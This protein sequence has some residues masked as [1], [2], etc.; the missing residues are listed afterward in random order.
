MKWW[1]CIKHQVTL[2]RCPQR[3]TL[4][5]RQPGLLCLVEKWKVVTL[6]SS[7]FE[8]VL[9]WA[10]AEFDAL[11]VNRAGASPHILPLCSH[12]SPPIWTSVG[13][14]GTYTKWGQK[15]NNWTCSYTIH[16]NTLGKLDARKTDHTIHLYQFKNGTERLQ[17]LC[18]YLFF[19]TIR[20]I[21]TT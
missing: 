12:I 7:A 17:I 15:V 9:A 13:E 3:F 1:N 6:D 16:Y 11:I 21:A 10:A 18:K 8:G 19:N 2:L 14:R 5:A 4:S 20:A